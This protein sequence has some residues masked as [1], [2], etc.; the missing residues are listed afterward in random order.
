M[1]YGRVDGLTV[2]VAGANPPSRQCPGGARSPSSASPVAR[3]RAVDADRPGRDPAGAGAHEDPVPGSVHDVDVPHEV[4]RM[5]V[6]RVSVAREV[7]D[8]EDVV[9]GPADRVGRVR[10]R[11]PGEVV[12]VLLAVVAVTE[13][14]SVRSAALVEADRHAAEAARVAER[15]DRAAAVGDIGARIEHRV[16]A[17]GLRAAADR[18]PVTLV[19]RPGADSGQILGGTLTGV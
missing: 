3:R 6:L 1:R 4:V 8:V 9:P 11:G 2:Q 12:R 15:P 13:R 14:P 17:A 7:T 18:G 5:V 16:R 10:A 19:L